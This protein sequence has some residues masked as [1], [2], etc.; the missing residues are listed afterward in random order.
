MHGKQNHTTPLV[1]EIYTQKSINEE[2]SSLFTNGFLWNGK[3]LKP[4]KSQDYPQKPQR[5]CTFVAI[6]EHDSLFFHQIKI[7]S[8]SVNSLYRERVYT[9][10]ESLLL[11]KSVIL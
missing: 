6:S 10:T 2:N 8:L 11:P 5:N 7:T 1:S 3:N 9:V 4:E